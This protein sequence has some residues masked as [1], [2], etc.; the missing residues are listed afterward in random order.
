MKNSC[1]SK[2]PLLDPIHTYMLVINRTL[3]IFPSG[4][5][6]SEDSISNAIKIT[7]YL[8]E[9]HL[10]WDDEDLIN[11]FSLKV[12]KE[13]FLYGM[14]V[15]C[16]DG[17]PYKALNSV[18]PNKFKPWELKSVPNCYWTKETGILASKWLIEEVLK[19][20]EATIKNNLSSKIF[21]DYNLNSMFRICFNQSTYKLIN[22][23]YPNKFKKS[24]F[25]S[26]SYYK[27]GNLLHTL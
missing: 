12:F 26:Y 1:N 11:K 6:N 14:L 17:S 19:W 4:F 20:D 9:N 24:D 23:T 2:S 16:F 21:I 3:K 15:S 7:K 5:W 18:Y 8:I 22:S 27:V 13:N 10:K 25:K